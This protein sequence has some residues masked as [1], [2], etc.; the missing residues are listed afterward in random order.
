M[1]C[2]VDEVRTTRYGKNSFR[3]EAVQVWNSLPEDIRTVDKYKDFV[4]LIR[5]WTDSKCKCAMCE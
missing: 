1:I 2:R 5:T 4:R 3:F